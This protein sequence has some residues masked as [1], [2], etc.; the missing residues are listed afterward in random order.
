ML[1]LPRDEHVFLAADQRELAAGVVAGADAR[2]WLAIAP[3]VT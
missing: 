1:D 3:D 2:P